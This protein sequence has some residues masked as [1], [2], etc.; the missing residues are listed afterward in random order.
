[1]HVKRVV[2]PSFGTYLGKEFIRNYIQTR[3][4]VRRST[5]G[6]RYG[7]N[8]Y[9]FLK[10]QRNFSEK[11]CYT[12]STDVNFL[13]LK[14]NH[15]LRTEFHNQFREYSTEHLIVETY[16]CVCVRARAKS[17]K[18]ICIS[19]MC[20]IANITAKGCGKYP[21]RNSVWAP[22]VLIQLFVIFLDPFWRINIEQVVFKGLTFMTCILEYLLR[23][24]VEIPTVLCFRDVSS[25]RQVLGWYF[26]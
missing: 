23:N 15:L 9:S 24:S 17:S 1:M 22:I 2:C 12:Y 19:Q 5:N 26:S 16:C 6:Y 4:T 18:K 8:I 10:T 14:H 20:R 25:S 13:C 11:G 3:V 21:I 7:R